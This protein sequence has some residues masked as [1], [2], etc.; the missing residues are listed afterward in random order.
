[1]VVR[2]W[3]PESARHER[4][5]SRL[6]AVAII[7][8]LT[9]EAIRSDD[10]ALPALA[11]SWAPALLLLLAALVLGLAL[12]RLA[13]LDWRESVTIAVEVCI[14]NTVLG[15][16]VATQAL[17]SLEAAVPIVVFMSFQLPVG[18]GVLVVYNLVQR[19]RSPPM[20]PQRES[21]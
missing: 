3:R 17:G 14:K 7:A 19:R 12:P 4:W 15:L 21:T 1:M 13:R 10:P 11:S 8:A 9:I 6:S 5:L 20:G 16:F 2:A 18:I